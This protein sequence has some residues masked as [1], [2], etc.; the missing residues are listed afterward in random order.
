MWR[1][2]S[3]PTAVGM[4]LG[5]YD[6]HGYPNLFPGDTGE[7]TNEVNQLI[8]SEGDATHPRH[9]EDYCLPMDEW[10]N[11]IQPDKS[12][13]ALVKDRHLSDC[14]ADY[15]FTSWSEFGCHYGETVVMDQY[16]YMDYIGGGFVQY[17]WYKGSANYAPN[18]R[19]YTMGEVRGEEAYTLTWSVLTRQI[20]NNRPMVFAVDDDA[21]GFVGHGEFSQWIICDTIVAV[22]G[23]RD[24][25]RQQ[26]GCLDTRH[27]DIRWYDFAPVASG[28]PF[29]VYAGWSFTLA[30][31][32]PMG[33]M[34]EQ[35]MWKHMVSA[36]AN[37]DGKFDTAWVSRYDISF[38][39][40]RVVI[41]LDLQLVGA[42]PGAALKQQWKDG[43]ENIWSNAFDIVDG[44]YRY[45][46]DVNVNW[47]TT[48]T[49]YVVT[50][51][52]GK[53]RHDMVNWY[54]QTDWGAE[55]QDEIAA[56]E[57]GHMMGLYDEYDGANGGSL[58]PVTQLIA[59][60]S[61]M[62]DLGPPHERHYKGII[63][64]LEAGSG[65]DLILAQSPLPPYPSDGPVSDFSDPQNIPVADAGPDQTVEQT[66]PAGAEAT[67]NG[68]GSYDP[69]LGPQPLTYSWSWAGGMA[70]GVSP[71]VLFPPGTTE[72]TLTVSDGQFTS[73][74]TVSVTVVDTTPP[75]VVMVNP[76]S[77]YALQDGV[78]FIAA[79]TDIGS[80]VNSVTFSIREDNGGDGV[81]VGFEDI[82]GVHEL[83]T[84]NWKLWFDTQ[85]LPDGYYV[86]V[87]EATD[88]AG[89]VGSIKVPYSIRNWAVIELLPSTAKNKAGR[90]MPIKFSL[91]VAA[92]VDPTQPFVYNEELTIKIYASSNPS[93]VLQT[94]TYGN[95][96]RN[97]RIAHAQYITNFKTLPTPKQYTVSVNRNTFQI[98]SF[99]FQTRA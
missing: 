72:V 86:V 88:N 20:D 78:T 70:N 26:Y 57:A 24:T 18:Y 50:V 36:D 12:S 4:I 95:G 67:L 5:Y 25:P 69:D 29:G 49:Y 1:R 30:P 84:D 68:S 71:T 32:T 89:N 35:T 21:D 64:W 15:M 79:A 6:T 58:D 80:G 87:V 54:T 65:R 75:S 17:V 48:K 2:G 91:R 13:T 99:N 16:G 97:Y 40:G 74:D 85:Q 93:I 59:T 51:H 73:T 39:N 34:N 23:Y 94:S 42:D 62:A 55:M 92:A 77:G 60:N 61:I 8:A 22:I 7:Q 14:L 28:Q 96:A 11:P 76:P 47:V 41:E 19:A 52:D 27:S 43:I 46:I 44:N 10:P 66:S 63:E 81:P 37:G 56:H 53:G 3:A 38:Q 98:G 82:H 33:N 9:Y 83:G 31:S 45:P 90:T